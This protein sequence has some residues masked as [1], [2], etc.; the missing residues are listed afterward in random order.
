[1]C[2]IKKGIEKG[3]EMKKILVLLVLLAVFVGCGKKEAKEVVDDGSYRIGI[4]TPSLVTS[5]DEYRAGE[6]MVK[7]YPDIVRHVVLPVN[8]NAELETG[9]SQIVSLADDPKMKGIVVVSGQSG[10]IAA[11]QKVKEKRP[12][13][14][15][16]ASIM[17]DP[18]MMDQYI[19]F[20]I[21][22]NWVKR[23]E[24]IAKR[25]H[26]LGAETIIHYSF[27]THLSKEV[28]VKRKDSMKEA[29]ENLGMNFVEIMTPDPQTG[30]GPTPMQQFLRE[31]LP[32]Q[33]AKYGT[34]INVFGTNC[35]MY[36]VIL[37]EAIKD[38]FMV[39][40]QCCPTSTQGYPT[41]MGL[42][43]DEEDLGNY[44][45]LNEMISEK[46]SE[47]EVTGKLGA[48]PIPSSVF[49]PKFSVELAMRVAEDENYD[50]HNIDNLNE[51]GKEVSG[52]NVDFD[53]F[54]DLNNYFVMVMDSIMF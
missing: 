4:V 42:E 33:V 28:I 2:L 43:I 25:S 27:P 9:I 49:V 38:K 8:F 3:E 17:D 16:I 23:G 30:S 47:L 19:D 1:V 11:L 22:T 31:D 34:N 6:E 51:L 54:M 37:D 53:R 35:P 29:A 18:I 24:G 50:Y 45:K 40:E 12:D 48:W 41:V 13:I 26:D 5:E 14:I 46:A 44:A 39:V 21:D 32:R 52:V 15:T 20:S 10:L 36:D 7:K